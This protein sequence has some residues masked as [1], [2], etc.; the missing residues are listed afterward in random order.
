MILI[1]DIHKLESV[2]GREMGIVLILAILGLQ[3]TLI[4]TGIF[5][6]KGRINSLEGQVR[7]NTVHID[8]QANKINANLE[9]VAQFNEKALGTLS[10]NMAMCGYEIKEVKDKLE[11]V[12]N[13]TLLVR[14]S[15]FEIDSDI[16]EL[17]KTIRQ[18]TAKRLYL[19]LQDKF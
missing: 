4:L 12:N 14:Q 11:I 6:L 13:N 1:A 5:T 8:G 2:G 15:N 19:H 16:A 9:E 7:A 18:E 17:S 10:Q 3:T